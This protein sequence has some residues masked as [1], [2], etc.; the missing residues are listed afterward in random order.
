MVQLRADFIAP[1]SSVKPVINGI[2]KPCGSTMSRGC[3]VKYA[4]GKSGSMTGGK[5]T[6]GSVSHSY[7]RL[8]VQYFSIPTRITCLVGNKNTKTYKVF[9]ESGRDIF[10]WNITQA[11]NSFRPVRLTI[12]SEFGCQNGSTFWRDSIV[13]W[14]SP[15]IQIGARL[16]DGFRE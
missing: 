16:S 6:I 9:I 4:P 14:P 13:R 12:T 1:S 7:N 3:L 5:G 11:F 8:Q 15:W 2:D 10:R